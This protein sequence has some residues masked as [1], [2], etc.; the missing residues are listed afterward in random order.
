MIGPAKWSPQLPAH[1]PRSSVTRCV[2]PAV[3]CPTLCFCLSQSP[4]DVRKQAHGC[5]RLAR[6]QAARLLG[7][8][9]VHRSRTQPAP[10]ASR[11]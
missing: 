6:G 1:V 8:A 3:P 7:S 5:T 9:H 2:P 4:G 11:A 10:F